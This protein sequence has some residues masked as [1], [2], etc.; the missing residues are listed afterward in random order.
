[1]EIIDQ[2]LLNSISKQAEES[3]RLRMN[4]NF[5]PSNDSK[6]QRLLNA[7][8]PGTVLPIHRHQHTSETYILLR[9][10]LNVLLYSENHELLSCTEINPNKGVYGIDI[11]AGEWHTIEV[12]ETGTVIF[13]VKE[14][15][16]K[17]L[18]EEDILI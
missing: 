6:A 16:Y 3:P 11:P 17:P 1:M 13:E 18:T 14:G 8:E 2:E 12:L 4:N 15:P 10:R 5:H 9:G 7:L